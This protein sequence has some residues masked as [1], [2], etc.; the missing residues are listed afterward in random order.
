MV[1]KA[2]IPVKTANLYPGGGG[3]DALCGGG[4]LARR[5]VLPGAELAY[6][7]H[8][9]GVEGTMVKTLRYFLI[10]WGVLLAFA[11]SLVLM[12]LWIRWVISM[13]AWGQALSV[14]AG[15]SLIFWL[16]A[17]DLA[18]PRSVSPRW[19]ERESDFD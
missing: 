17:E 13:P 3:V 11:A 16:I 8:R 6:G 15:L 19:S 5:G 12:Y 10:I 14:I 7:M 2:D 1:R 4:T 9:G 18:R